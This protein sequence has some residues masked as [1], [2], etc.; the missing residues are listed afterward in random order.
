M[1][2][3]EGDPAV[4]A[5]DALRGRS[6]ADAMS[7]P[8]LSREAGLWHSPSPS[9]RP[10]A[11]T[12][13]W[14]VQER[15]RGHESTPRRSS[16]TPSK[17]ATPGTT[18]GRAVARTLPITGHLLPATGHLLPAPPGPGTLAPER[19]NWLPRICSH[20]DVDE[21][22]ESPRP[23]GGNGR[24]RA[25]ATTSA[26]CHPAGPSPDVCSA[27]RREKRARA[28]YRPRQP[29]SAPSTTSAW[30]RLRAGAPLQPSGH[31]CPT[32]A[33]EGASAGYCAERTER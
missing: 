5:S 14:R 25:F 20:S 19:R 1:S 13:P 28:H 26:A 21:R 23:W 11:S 22:T 2:C 4:R 15:R 6:S 7:S 8:A 3:E 30:R 29:G 32:R 16:R 10:E 24:R 9:A 27:T 31:L 17:R 12:H 33:L 18:K